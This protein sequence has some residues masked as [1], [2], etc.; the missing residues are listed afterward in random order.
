MAE[1]EITIKYRELLP[2]LAYR[3]LFIILPCYILFFAW[4]SIVAIFSF[5]NGFTTLQAGLIVMGT[6]SLILLVLCLLAAVV[7]DNTIFVTRD[8]LSFPF[9]LLPSRSMRKQAKW[10]QLKGVKFRP[11]SS[12]HLSLTFNDGR[13]INLSLSRLGE[14]ALEDLIVAI[15]VWGGGGDS[16]PEL[17]EARTYLHGEGKTESLGYTELW[18]EELARRFGSTNFI[19]LE[20][21]Q[22]IR[23]GTLEVER[24]VA[25]GGMSAIYQVASLADQKLHKMIL[26]ESVVPDDSNEELKAKAVELLTREAKLL[27]SLD[28]PRIARVIDIFVEEG[29][30]YLLIEQLKG[31]DLRRLVQEHGAQDEREV[32]DWAMQI[33][34]IVA[35]LHGCDP[36]VIHKDLTPSNLIVDD[37]GLISLIDFGAANLFLGTA[38]G[39]II[40]KQAYIAPEQLRGKARQS[41]DLY[42]LGATLYFLLTGLDPEPISVN[43][44]RNANG[45]V[46]AP[47]DQLVIA[48]TQMEPEDRP[49]TIE[50]VI[51][52]ILK[53]GGKRR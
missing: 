26:K 23:D 6:L 37:D 35:Y 47:M 44:P 28:H 1:A 51:D 8:G 36:P 29:R 34:D 27:A 9:L 12:G 45:K 25:F 4:T 49:Q 5:L 22:K 24:Q 53:M 52:T 31:Q 18:E 39:T 13:R 38:T 3:C 33:A 2:T 10:E 11:G 46:S 42:A 7:A 17:L 40:G 48:L 16:F 20:P 43:S 32:L 41:S 14:K 19:P 21:G 15:D 50:D 30:H